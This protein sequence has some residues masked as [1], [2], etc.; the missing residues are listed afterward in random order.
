MIE[1]ATHIQNG[2]FILNQHAFGHAHLNVH[3]YTIAYTRTYTRAHGVVC[4]FMIVVLNW[5]LS[6]M[7]AVDAL[8]IRLVC[9]IAFRLTLSFMN[10]HA[11]LHAPTM[12]NHINKLSC[13]YVEQTCQVH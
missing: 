10:D 13:L 9:T 7:R 12:N 8:V 3:T 11:T 6:N 4:I 5:C 1:Y 2:I